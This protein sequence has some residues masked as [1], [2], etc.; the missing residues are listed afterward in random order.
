MG[1]PPIKPATILPAP[2]AKSSLL[3]LVTLRSASRLSMASMLKSVSNDAIIAIISPVTSTLPFKNPLKS[4]S[5]KKLK[6]LAALFATSICTKCSLPTINGLPVNLKISF[7]KMAAITATKAPG[8]NF[9]LFL[10]KG[11][12]HISMIKIETIQIINTPPLIC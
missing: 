2:C 9:T 8:T 11:L 4:G 7:I 12:P 5:V 1:K 3:V 6:K 10:I